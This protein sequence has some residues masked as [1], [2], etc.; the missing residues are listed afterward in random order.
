MQI[1]VCI[2]YGCLWRLGG[3]HERQESLSAWVWGLGTDLVRCLP[4]WHNPY[5]A[6]IFVRTPPS[7]HLHGGE[8]L[9]TA[10]FFSLSLLSALLLAF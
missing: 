10:S 7:E 1:P 2:V 5:L 9:E 3:R 6:I 4:L 8:M